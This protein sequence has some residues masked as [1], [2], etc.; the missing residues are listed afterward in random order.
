[1]S[2]LEI[3]ALAAGQEHSDEVRPFADGP[4]SRRAVM[5]I[6]GAPI[7]TTQAIRPKLVVSNAEKQ[8]KT[9]LSQG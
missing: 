4:F 6:E 7:P 3:V 9:A 8:R 1:M 2:D 5:V